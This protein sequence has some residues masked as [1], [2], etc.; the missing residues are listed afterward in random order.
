MVGRFGG[1][2]PHPLLLWRSPIWRDKEHEV[3]QFECFD[4]VALFE[5]HEDVFAGD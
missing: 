4:I 5:C 2:S 1:L 3:V